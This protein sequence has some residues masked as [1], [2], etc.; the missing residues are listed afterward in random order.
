M[1]IAIYGISEEKRKK[2]YSIK[3]L[4]CKVSLCCGDELII[5]SDEKSH[6]QGKK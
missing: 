6:M 2:N 4:G 3:L 1:I 5:L